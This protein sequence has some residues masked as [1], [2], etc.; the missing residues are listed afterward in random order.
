MLFVSKMLYPRKVIS[1]PHLANWYLNKVVFNSLTKQDESLYKS[2][3]NSRAPNL[4]QSLLTALFTKPP[5]SQPP[6]GT[7]PH[8]WLK[9][10]IGQSKL[11]TVLPA[12]WWIALLL[13]MARNWANAKKIEYASSRKL[14]HILNTF[15]WSKLG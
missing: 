1:H 8:S 12:A 3:R 10:L 7:V 13:A 5:D 6:A 2:R 14:W 11:L 9:R 4:Y 15:C